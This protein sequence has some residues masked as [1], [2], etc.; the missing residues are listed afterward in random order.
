[1]ELLGAIFILILLVVV[2]SPLPRYLRPQDRAFPMWAHEAADTKL[3]GPKMASVLTLCAAVW[4]LAQLAVKY[5][6]E[7]P[8]QPAM[9]PACAEAER[10]ASHG[11]TTDPNY[12]RAKAACRRAN[13]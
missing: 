10:L 7:H 13:R 5:F 2:V 1:M 8:Q 4:I 12:L 9:N 3:I 11:D 6:E